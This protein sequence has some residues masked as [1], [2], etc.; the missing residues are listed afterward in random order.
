MEIRR[1]GKIAVGII[2]AMGTIGALHVF[3]F[4][5]RAAEYQAARAEY[6]SALERY[7]AQGTAPNINEIQRFRYET[8]KYRRDYWRAVEKLHVAFPDYLGAS[9]MEASVAQ[10]RDKLWDVLTELEKKRLEGET[11]GGPNLTFMSD[12]IW[13]ITKA[14]PKAFDT[15]AVDD[16]LQKLRDESRLL[17]SLTPGT[18]AYR[19]REGE[20]QKRLARLGLDLTWRDGIEEIGP[21]N[22]KIKR[23]KGLKDNFGQLTA[24]LVTI[25]RIDQVMKRLQ[26]DFFSGRPSD[27]NRE[28]MYQLF[29]IE[30]PKDSSGTENAVLA[31]RQGQA[32]LNIID[33]AKQEGV[34]SIPYV[35]FHEIMPISWV[36][37]EIAKKAPETPKPEEMFFG[38]FGEQG[39][40]MMMMMG[41]EGER[42]EGRSAGRWAGS[43][44]T[45]TPV[46]DLTATGV[47]VEIVVEGPNSS[48]MSFIYRL[49]HETLP[50]EVD[51]LRIRTAPKGDGK[52]QA[53]IFVNV[54]AHAMFIGIQREVDV[55]RKVV[56]TDIELAD[57]AL[58]PGAREDALRDGLIVIE[59]GSP[60]LVE[61]SPTPFPTPEGATPV[62]PAAPTG[63]IDEMM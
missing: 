51:R 13:N 31:M 29:R 55:R 48:I 11:G 41:M 8:L 32:L 23:V 19:A 42:G 40:E 36:D 26:E 1:S 22:A 34:E 17:R 37:P 46:V 59:N 62:P 12:R 60:K 7:N 47:P 27:A 49:S 44:V 3:I 4:R 45:P 56:E 53:Q 43:A 18:A 2:A 16:E 35:K 9:L 50:Y 21:N 33:I 25:N 63:P 24:V 6:N 58:R 54:I 20:Y 52:V 28:E 61:P 10:Q 57:M 15:V 14:L 38:D 5:S 39:G 30:W